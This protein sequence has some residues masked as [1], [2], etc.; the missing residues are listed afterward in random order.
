MSKIE[1]LYRSIPAAFGQTIPSKSLRH[2]VLSLSVAAHN[3]SSTPQFKEKYF[4]H[5]TLATGSL[6]HKL[7]NPVTLEESD[8]IAVLILFITGWALDNKNEASVHLLGLVSILEAFMAPLRN[9]GDIVF[10]RAYGTVIT[11]FVEISGIL[12]GDGLRTQND[13]FRNRIRLWEWFPPVSTWE[14]VGDD[15]DIFLGSLLC[16]FNSFYDLACAEAQRIPDSH[17]SVFQQRT[18]KLLAEWSSM[19]ASTASCELF[20]LS[21]ALKFGFPW[22]A[23]FEEVC[24]AV[25]EESDLCS[26]FIGR[27]A[28]SAAGALLDCCNDAHI[29]VFGGMAI[30]DARGYC[31]GGQSMSLEEMRSW[32]LEK[33]ELNCKHPQ[34]TQALKLFW[35]KSDDGNC[36]KEVLWWGLEELGSA[37]EHIIKTRIQF[38]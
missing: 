29:L 21:S 5:T 31:I 3:L 28:S 24:E 27:R 4:I 35:D 38:C 25:L 33:M 10:L 30:H 12:F 23:E 22:V 36:L 13:K 8:V 16:L 1:Q 19:S 7:D 6:R 2:A 20:P 14:I 17:V 37:Y 18:Q 9:G 11:G 15:E 26:G 34:T 32:L